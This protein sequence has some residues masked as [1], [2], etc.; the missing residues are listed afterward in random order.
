MSWEAEEEVA[1]KAWDGRL[2]RRLLRYAGP[3]RWLFIKSF[4]VL[5]SLFA[6]DLIGPWIWQASLDGPVQ[7]ALSS[8][9]GTDTAPF[10][11]ELLMLVAVYVGILLVQTWLRYFE[12]AT[13][14]LTGQSVIHDLRRHIYSHISSLDLAWFDR[15]P[16]GALVTRVSSD[17]ENLAELFTAGVVTLAFDMIRV[18]VVLALLFTIHAPLAL[19][20]TLMT[21]I[22]ILISLMFRGGARRAHRTVRAELARLNGYLA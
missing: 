6:L 11:H 22:L 16:T 12:V 4:M 5:A 21:P 15:R 8:P 18:V 3:H 17:V 14:I 19:V 9:E 7:D 13:L 10:I 20:V 1:G 2:F